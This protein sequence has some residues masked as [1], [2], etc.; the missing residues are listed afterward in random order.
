MKLRSLGLSEAYLNQMIN[1]LSLISKSANLDSTDEVLLLI[2]KRKITDSSKANLC[3]FYSHYAKF[4]QIPFSKPKYYKDTKQ[5]QLP[6]RED[7]NTIIGHSSKKYAII[8]SIIRDNGLRP[9]EIANLTLNDINLDK[10]S[11]S[12]ISAKHG[13]PRT[14]KL[15]SETL[16]MLK[17]YV[18][19]NNF[20]MNTKLFP[21]SSVITNTYCA[22]RSSIAKKLCKPHL[23]K[24][25]LYDLRHYFAS[26][27][28]HE[29]KDIV[30]TQQMLGHRSIL[31]TMVYTHL[32][33]FDS[34]NNF[35]TATA[36]TIDEAQ[37]LL[38][39]GFEYVV[40]FDSIMLFRKRK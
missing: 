27:L 24:I 16:A 10:G 21:K 29:T 39:N 26:T 7:I 30:L 25:R 18:Q 14:V 35:Y 1:A 33:K 12:V 2:S 11:I 17:T 15:K 36:K 5:I 23:M 4:Y 6:T 31:N 20:N 22:L 8:Y 3:D 37:K 38:E 9:V 34:E 32:I 40:T 13:N 19:S 28:Y